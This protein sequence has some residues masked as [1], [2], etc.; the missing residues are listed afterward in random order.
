ML[1]K[2]VLIAPNNAITPGEQDAIHALLQSKAI[3]AIFVKDS[4]D[5][6]THAPDCVISLSPEVPKLTHFPTY[7][8]MQKP[9]DTYL[10]LPRYVRN[11]LTYDGYLTTCEQTKESLED[12]LFGARKLAACVA[13]FDFHAPPLS[14]QSSHF[15]QVFYFEPD[16]TQ[17]VFS[18]ALKTL[19][20]N[21]PGFKMGAYRFGLHREVLILAH[22]T[23]VQTAYQQAG[24]GLTL[25]LTEADNQRIDPQLL[26][27]IASGAAALTPF[28]ETLYTLFGD[29]LWYL[30][31]NLTPCE[32]VQA[33][34]KIIAQ[35]QAT[36]TL[37]H[38]KAARALAIYQAKFSFESVFP[39]LT[40][41][42]AHTL[43]AK[44][45]APETHNE[46]QVTYLLQTDGTPD[47]LKRALYSLAKQHYPNLNVIIL[48]T[49]ELNA[50]SLQAEF[51]A[52]TLKTLPAVETVSK[53][54]TQALQ[55]I[56]SEW[57]GILDDTDELHPNHIRSLMKTL[58]YHHELDW[59]GPVKLAYSG[60]ICVHPE[61]TTETENEFLDTALG[62]QR[63]KR[64]IDQFHFYQ[65][66]KIAH[67]TWRMANTW[68]AHRSLLD[69]EILADAAIVDDLYL[70][71]QF[72]QRTAFAFS[73][74]A[75]LYHHVPL[76]KPFA[77][78]GKPTMDAKRIALRNF[79]RAFP[80]DFIYDS[81]F[82]PVGRLPQPKQPQ[83]IDE[84]TAPSLKHHIQLAN[85]PICAP[86]YLSSY[87]AYTPPTSE[88][89]I[90]QVISQAEAA[91]H[92]AT[93]QAI[94]PLAWR[95]LRKIKRITVKLLRKS[96]SLS[97]E[98]LR[99][100]KPS[101]VLNKKSAVGG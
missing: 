8:L 43:Q 9:I 91:P 41:L 51:P 85:Q 34:Q 11:I 78:A 72:A 70:E 59:R 22:Q 64:V 42:H 3:A 7:G 77:K 13:H 33:I 62:T 61:G 73:V 5:I 93:T 87:H 56:D 100:I 40:A 19:Q 92:L 2:I 96:Y 97:A 38:E 14:T 66:Y 67:H 31:P 80:A 99:R 95:I 74:E 36:P 45:F 39:H 79:S 68:L 23:A 76:Q 1:K 98:M 16:L 58:Q 47:K 50:A 89:T 60:S 25:S 48:P 24:I 71:L 101:L 26:T 28:S 54:R 52:L 10:E 90:V 69:H 46:P 63:Q 32:L 15:Q 29:S 94:L 81:I 49:V 17:S 65:G 35:I 88:P 20:A 82:N 83:Y 6:I 86:N 44:G 21:L 27:I 18:N 12:L 4:D 75:T 84:Q 57:F 30:S 37:A 55:T 53:A